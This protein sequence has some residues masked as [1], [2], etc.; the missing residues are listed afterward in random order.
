MPDRLF[1][2]FAAVVA[3]SWVCAAHAATFVQLN[4]QLRDYIGQGVN[5][6]VT[7]ADGTI[8]A[9]K[10]DAATVQV[11]FS[12]ATSRMSLTFSAPSLGLATY[13]QAERWPI[14]PV[15]LPGMEISADGRAC[16]ALHG[17][18]T[19]RELVIAT[20]GTV[21]SFAADF[22]QHCEHRQS[23]AYGGVRYN[24]SVPYTDFAPT[25]FD[26]TTI[27]MFGEPGDLLTGGHS[28]TFSNSDGR[29]ESHLDVNNSLLFRDEDIS[30]LASVVMAGPDG[31]LVHETNYY[32]WSRRFPFNASGHPGLDVVAIGK[33]CN[34]LTG[35]FRVYEMQLDKWGVVRKFAADFVE[36]CEGI[37]TSTLHGSVRVNS[38]WPYSPPSEETLASYIEY[39]D[40]T[41]DYSIERN[42]R[43][44]N[45]AHVVTTNSWGTRI[46]GATVQYQSNCGSGFSNGLNT[47]NVV[48]DASGT[49]T[50][51]DWTAPDAPITSCTIS[52]LMPGIGNYL[53]FTVAVTP[54]APQPTVGYVDSTH[55]F[56]VAPGTSLSGVRVVTLDSTGAR[57]PGAQL[58][59]V[60]TCGR[61][62][63]GG[64][65]VTFFSDSS[66]VGTIP[67]W[68]APTTPGPCRIDV[69]LA[70]N[71]SAAALSFN[72]NVTAPGTP[73]PT[74]TANGLEYLDPTHVYSVSYGATF[75]GLRVV[76]VVLALPTP[77]SA[78]M[79]VANQQ[80]TWSAT[81]GTFANGQSTFTMMSDSS[82]T[83]MAPAWT[84]PGS[85]TSCVVNA[86]LT[87]AQVT[88]PFTMNLMASGPSP[89]SGPPTTTAS[90]QSPAGGA[91]NLSLAPG[92]GS[93]S[94][95]NFSV[96]NPAATDLFNFPP[97][98]LAY[99]K[100]GYVDLRVDGCAS[101]QSVTLT[102]EFPD[103][104][105]ATA[106]WWKFG[107]T[108]DN[109]TNHWY[110]I[111]S[112]VDGKRISFTI[113]DGGL[114]D[115][116]L[117]V[118]GSI[119]DLG[120][121]GIPGGVTQDLWWS[122]LTENGWGMSI[123]QHR[124]V[125]FANVFVY[126]A[127]G[128][129]VWYVLPSGTWNA[130]HTAYT[131]NLYLPKGSPFYAY[132]VSKF[133]IGASVGAATLTFA[134]PNEATFAYT[135]N[136][137][138]AQKN[139]SRLAFGPVDAPLDQ[140]F[141][142]LWWAGT[143]QNGW[144]IALLQQ[145]SSLFALWFT[146]DADGKA[147]WFVMPAGTWTNHSQYDGKLY[148]A[149]GPAWLGVP[150]DASR[151]HTTEA[152]TFRLRFGT[153]TATFDYTVDS[154]SGSISLTRIPF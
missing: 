49:A 86:S 25:P 6:G 137:I 73:A 54:P 112:T 2:R 126:D 124:D 68:T 65:Q 23:A 36:Y 10:V 106:V 96:L 53:N 79:P 128:N 40:S 37:I 50:A 91:V 141:A 153:D 85:G 145:Y 80:V 59:A 105:P 122:G 32:G 144:G 97:S 7:T 123:I 111:P 22:E 81:C 94:I 135:I 152:G 117:M 120:M 35:A 30:D 121:L 3:A 70:S 76:T 12:G 107:P 150:Y 84:A 24:S 27:Q 11:I 34:T 57:L 147:T 4:S 134:N 51:P 127:Q 143:A 46:P 142:D 69:W 102:I 15:G 75:N 95:A 130:A 99:A 87:Q 41:H 82:A 13:D 20:N 129:P 61:F 39:A 115:D 92:S 67:T 58:L 28:Y 21:T 44:T 43:L 52:A 103:V 77:G 29:I 33:S 78:S 38:S 31:T 17:K 125:L 116:D 88:L 62:D 146:Y 138:T 45:F 48:S 93:C 5:R 110:P 113:T 119:R 136:G 151:H 148:R 114:G 18:F 47:M 100:D 8:T 71:M 66:G 83:A 98:S 89:P 55:S 60:G 19:V 101:G 26:V 140:S 74:A 108:P 104:L 16:S 64:S 154:R 1:L 139:I 72:V 63:I 109:H 132:D 14:Q 9:T 131:G 42:H 56:D 90:A 133:D 149:Q 118:N